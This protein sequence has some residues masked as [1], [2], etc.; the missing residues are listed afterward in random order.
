MYQIVPWTH[1]AV[2]DFNEKCEALTKSI[3]TWWLK[4]ETVNVA[5]NA[6]INKRIVTVW[7]I[8]CCVNMNMTR[9]LMLLTR[10]SPRRHTQISIFSKKQRQLKAKVGSSMLTFCHIQKEWAL[11]ELKNSQCSVAL[12]FYTVL[13]QIFTSSYVSH[14]I[15]MYL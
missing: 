3:N 4:R 15:Q 13:M 6:A 11:Q 5:E 8:D 2:D 12:M 9:P 1:I 14:I 10:G 7:C